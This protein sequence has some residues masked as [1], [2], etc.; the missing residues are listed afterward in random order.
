M[1]V[2]YGEGSGD[3]PVRNG[4]LKGSEI[5]PSLLMRDVSRPKVQLNKRQKETYAKCDGTHKIKADDF[6]EYPYV[7]FYKRPFN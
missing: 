4:I 6:K 7:V 2:V 1:Q 3:Y 5:W